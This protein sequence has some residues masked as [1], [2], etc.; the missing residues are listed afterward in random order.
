MLTK[1]RETLQAIFADEGMQARWQRY[2]RMYSYARE[3]EFREINDVLLM[4]LSDG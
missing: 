3:I 2:A 4:L 1:H